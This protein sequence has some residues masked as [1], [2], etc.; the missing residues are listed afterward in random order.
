MKKTKQ[1][2]SLVELIV[3]ISILVIISVI[4]ISWRWERLDKLYNTRALSDIK[5][6]KNWLESY[7]QRKQKLPMP[8][9]NI[10]FFKYD[11]SYM[12]SYENNETFWVYGSIV[13]ETLPNWYLSMF[14]VDKRTNSYYAY[15]KAKKRLEFELA[16]LQI[17][18]GEA[19]AMVDWNYTAFEWPYNLG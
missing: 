2:Y 13:E 7:A 6:M 15:W 3:V 12:H 16:F 10:N 19:R 8:W 4:V 17:I 5:A 14:S 9:W 11:S 18:D 1:A